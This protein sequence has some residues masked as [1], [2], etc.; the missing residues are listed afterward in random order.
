MQK[1]KKKAGLVFLIEGFSGS[2]KS[3]LSKLLHKKIEKKNGNTIVLSGDNFRK[4]LNLNKYKKN[5]RINNSHLFSKLINL[6]SERNIN[7]IFS[8]V[9]LNKKIRSIYKKNIKNF[10][11]IFI[12]T[13]I[14]KI[15][16]LKK[17]NIYI[18][19]K[20]ILLELI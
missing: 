2:G 11:L 10:F 8:I 15:I 20:K 12:D 14:N 13:D 5:D 6:L 7:V 19:K 9:G 17:K 4:V 1:S 3:T 16:K 18:T